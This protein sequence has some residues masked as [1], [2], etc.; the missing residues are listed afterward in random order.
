M[1]YNIDNFNYDIINK[2]SILKASSNNKR[3]KKYLDVITAFDIETSNI[4]QNTKNIMYIWQFQFDKDFTI[5]GR[6]WPDF[7]TFLERVRKKL[8]RG[9]KLVV[10]VHNLSYEFQYLKGLYYFEKDEVFCTD[11]RKILYCSMF[12]QIEFRCSYFL[13][14]MSLNQ[15]TYQM[16][17]E[18]KKLSGLEFD[19][20]KLRYPWTELTEKELEYCVND[21]KGL[22]QALYK[23]FEI[24]GDNVLTIPLTSTGMVRRICQKAM[25]RY[26]HKQL[27]DM[28]PDPDVY[29]M[30]REAFRGGNTHANRYYVSDIVEN[31]KSMDIVSSYPAV[32]I[33]CEY[34]MS[35]FILNPITTY[36]QLLNIVYNKHQAV[37]MRIALYDIDLKD[38]MT[39]C[40]YLTRD[41]CRNIEGGVYDNGRIL[42]ADY[43]ETTLTDIDFKII[44]DMY[45]WTACTPFR[46]YTATYKKLPDMLLDTIRDFYSKKTELKGISEDSD[47]YFIYTL[48]KEYLNSIYGMCATDPVKDSIEFIADADPEEMFKLTDK[49]L[50]VLLKESNKKAF[51]SYAWGCWVTA[52]AR[53]RLQEAINIAG[54]QFVYCDTDSVKYTGDIDLSEFNQKRIKECIEHKGYALDK[55]GV[56]HYLG[57][58]EL[59]GVYNKF[60][61]LGAKKY[62][63]V[64][65]DDKLHITIAGVN[66]KEGAKELGCI[67][68]FKEGF[69]FNKAGGTETH[70]DDNVDERINIDGH[71]VH[72]TDNLVITNSTYTLGITQEYKDLLDGVIHIKYADRDIS[73]LYKYKR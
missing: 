14:N 17:V 70:L 27:T 38:I 61:T 71:D 5:V 18:N 66:K 8:P 59:D 43:L 72:I 45:K 3:R 7:F 11:S 63:Y 20:S 69:I 15:L 36:K 13:T 40:P 33:Q 60:A 50:E 47:D 29:R 41:K 54:T 23:K 65:N 30:L 68:N 28:L 49:P 46:V 34:P 55:D 10:Y 37:L 48:N 57:V 2:Y 1:I 52:H 21:V 53:A 24:T 73:G 58:F 44:K 51:L 56:V 16:K 26:N 31:V 42:R 39:G 32:M 4:V 62:C 9:T 6:S 22:V 67:E 35:K 64:D 12:D 19:Y 25:R